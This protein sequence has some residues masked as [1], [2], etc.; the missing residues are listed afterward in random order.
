MKREIFVCLD[1]LAKQLKLFSLFGSILFLSAF[2]G[3]VFTKNFLLFLPL[4]ILALIG[5]FCVWL[6]YRKIF[7]FYQSI[8]YLT[9]DEKTL[10][11]HQSRDSH[12]IEWN[13]I[14]NIDVNDHGFFVK[15]DREYQLSKALLN[16]NV[17]QTIE[18]L[19]R[20][21]EKYGNV[22]FIY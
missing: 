14:T 17:S 19:K 12:I 6:Y 4:A 18:M 13:K 7:S 15:T 16:D 9:L 1:K 3:W 5:L 10:T 8:P 22:R 20:Y 2:F 21:T 11:I